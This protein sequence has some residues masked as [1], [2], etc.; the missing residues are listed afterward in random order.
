MKGDRANG[1]F[2]VIFRNNITHHN[3]YNGL[4]CEITLNCDIYGNVVYSNGTEAGSE[5]GAGIVANG[6][7]FG[8]IHDNVIAWNGGDAICIHNVLRSDDHPD[9]GSYD[10]VREM[11]VYHNDVFTREPQ[12]GLAWRKQWNGG[13]LFESRMGNKGYGNRFYFAAADGSPDPSENAARFAWAGSHQTLS[14]FNNTPGEEG[15]S[16]MTEQQKD[17]VLSASGVPFSPE[18]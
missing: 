13:R 16:Y 4:K 5:G 9:Q 3:A 6:S 15:D 8:R 12:M 14:S 17:D 7:S 11:Q 10:Q 2:G 1:Q 18:R